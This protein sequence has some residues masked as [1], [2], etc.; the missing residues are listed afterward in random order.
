V[1]LPARWK[2]VDEWYAFHTNPSAKVTV[3]TTVDESTY[4]ASGASMG[5]NHP[6]SWQHL[7]DGGRSWYTAMGHTASSYSEPLFRGFLLGGILWAAG[8]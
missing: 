6:I 7:Y 2:R 1:H 8:R 5:A 4:D 3:L